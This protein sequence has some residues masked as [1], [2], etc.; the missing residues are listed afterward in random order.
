MPPAPNPELRQQVIAIY[1]RKSFL[2]LHALKL[3]YLGRDYPQGYDFFRPRLHRAFMAN[4]N[5]TDEGAIR[6]GIARADFVRKGN[7]VIAMGFFPMFLRQS[8]R[9]DEVLWWEPERS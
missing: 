9:R 8:A 3:L 5:L 7:V 4:A 2:S 6:A 1:K